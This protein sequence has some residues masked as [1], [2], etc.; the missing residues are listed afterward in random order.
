VYGP[1]NYVLG[2]RC[3][4]GRILVLYY[5]KPIALQTR[6]RTSQSYSRS[7]AGRWLGWALGAGYPELAARLAARLGGGAPAQ[8]APLPGE[9]G[10]DWSDWSSGDEEDPEDTAARRAQQRGRSRGGATTGARNATQ[11]GRSL[12]GKNGSREDKQRAGRL[13]GKLGGKRTAE[14]RR[15]KAAAAVLGG[16]RAQVTLQAKRRAKAAAA[17]LAE[18]E[19]EGR[20]MDASLAALQERELPELASLMDELAKAAAA[21]A[22]ERA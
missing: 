14:R 2:I 1:C 19:A 18:L 7:R 4:D 3:A 10:A 5:G 11:A 17:Q 8:R 22:A 21:A 16:Q 20:A 6:Y 9:D 12:G 13:G 15:A